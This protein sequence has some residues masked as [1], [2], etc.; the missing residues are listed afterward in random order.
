MVCPCGWSQLEFGRDSVLNHWRFSVEDGDVVLMRSGQ[1]WL[2]PLRY[3]ESVRSR[4]MVLDP[5]TFSVAEAEALLAVEK[6][7]GS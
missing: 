3:A 1:L 5:R 7:V 4:P 2:V 6:V